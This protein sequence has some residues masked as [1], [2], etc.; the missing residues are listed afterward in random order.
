MSNIG[1]DYGMGAS[2]RDP[3][4]DIRYGVISQHSVL[5]AWCD[6]AEPDYGNATCPKCGEECA[7]FNEDAHAGYEC[8]GRG[9]ADYACADCEYV[10]DSSEAF[11]DE[12]R[13][14][15]VNDGKYVL[16]DCIVSD[17]FVLKSPYYTFAQFCSPCAPGAGDLN[18]PMDDGIMTYCLGHDWF[19][20]KRAPYP[21]YRVSNNELVAAP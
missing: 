21:V 11:S 18:N 6:A 1:I 2:N 19:E 12:P 8:D 9:C 4:T 13:S 14:W 20:D 3:E 5:Q 16:T 15:N 17:I 7:D 10:F